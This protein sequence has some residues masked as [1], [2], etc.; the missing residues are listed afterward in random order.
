MYI[1][2]IDGIKY[3]PSQHHP[4]SAQYRI[5]QKDSKTSQQDRENP[6]KVKY[7]QTIH[8]DQLQ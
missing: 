6:A 4:L 5:G 3:L 2:I 7:I 8:F 1:R